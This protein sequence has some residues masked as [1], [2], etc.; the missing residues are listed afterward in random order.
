MNSR[1]IKK[2]PI[3]SQPLKLLE[4]NTGRYFHDIGMEKNFENKTQ[5]PG[6]QKSKVGRFGYIKRQTSAMRQRA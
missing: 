2:L 6:E 3:R 4:E 5:I 1:W